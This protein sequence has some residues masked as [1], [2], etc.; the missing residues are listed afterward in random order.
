MAPECQTE[1]VGDEQ[2]PDLDS[3][4][5][6]PLPFGGHRPSA[7][8]PTGHHESLGDFYRGL[9]ARRMKIVIFVFGGVAMLLVLLTA[10]QQ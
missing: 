8:S 9:G 2:N 10:L 6:E 5:A 1:V 7:L 3:D 4:A